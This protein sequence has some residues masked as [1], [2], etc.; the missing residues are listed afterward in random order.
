MNSS[1]S[2]EDGKHTPLHAN[3]HLPQ[4]QQPHRQSPRG[5]RSSS[6]TGTRSGDRKGC[7]NAKDR[8][9]LFSSSWFAPS[10]ALMT[11]L[12]LGVLAGS[13]MHHSRSGGKKDV[14]GSTTTITRGETVSY[15]L[16]SIDQ[17]RA[18][19]IGDDFLRLL[20]GTTAAASAA[21]NDPHQPHHHHKVSSSSL[22][23]TTT[24]ASSSASAYGK[25]VVAVRAVALERGM[26]EVENM[27]QDTAR[28]FAD[29]VSMSLAEDSYA[30]PF[31]QSLF[32]LQVRS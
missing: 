14:S 19:H 18:R 22:S 13:S 7:Q 16:P 30:A 4:Y 21:A 24:T 10:L 32:C 31:E 11:R 27:A 5:S 2:A 8:F 1:T 3:Q 6:D 25:Q 9:C 12:Q 17:A 29:I 28:M 26:R 20:H 23:T 15:P